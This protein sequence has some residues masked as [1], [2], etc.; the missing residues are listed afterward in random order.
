MGHLA[1]EVQRVLVVVHALPPAAAEGAAPR[2]VADSRG[3]RL[4]GTRQRPQVARRRRRTQSRR[5]RASRRPITS[6]QK[7][8]RCPGFVGSRP[9]ASALAYLTRPSSAG[10]RS[11]A[12]RGRR[13]VDRRRRSVSIIVC[14]RRNRRELRADSYNLGAKGALDEGRQPRGPRLR[15]SEPRVAASAMASQAGVTSSLTVDTA[16]VNCDARATCSITALMR[17]PH[18]AGALDFGAAWASELGAHLEPQRGQPP[19]LCALLSFLA[20]PSAPLLHLPRPR[21]SVARS[22]SSSFPPCSRPRY[23]I[24]FRSRRARHHEARRAPAAPAPPPP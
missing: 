5:R 16:G 15:T 9:A 11:V 2:R 20:L 4:P 3:A 22:P 24:V 19:P 12:A 1:G 17:F 10:T 18:R 6:G 21:A 23:Q 8:S 14:L 7:I 13:G